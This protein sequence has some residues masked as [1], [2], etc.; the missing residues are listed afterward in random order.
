V[1][2]TLSRSS[3]FSIVSLFANA[4]SSFH[5]LTKLFHSVFSYKLFPFCTM[6]GSS[7]ESLLKQLQRADAEEASFQERCHMR[8]GIIEEIKRLQE[9]GKAIQ[10]MEAI[11]V[12]HSWV[13]ASLERLEFVI[14]QELKIPVSKEKIDKILSEIIQTLDALNSQ[15]QLLPFTEQVKDQTATVLGDD[16]IDTPNETPLE[17]TAP[18][19]H[20]M[21]YK[22]A[23]YTVRIQRLQSP[24]RG[25]QQQSTPTLP[26]QEGIKRPSEA[27]L[28][29]ELRRNNI[30]LFSSAD[31]RKVLESISTPGFVLSLAE[32][33]E[34]TSIYSYN[35]DGEIL[36]QSYSNLS[37]VEGFPT[38]IMKVPERIKMNGQEVELTS[39]YLMKLW[40]M[41]S[42]T[43]SGRLVAGNQL[44]GLQ[45]IPRKSRWLT[46]CS[47]S[48]PEWEACQKIAW[49]EWVTAFI[50][51]LI[52]LWS[53]GKDL[54]IPTIGLWLT[55][56]TGEPIVFG[57]SCWY[58]GA[59][60][61]LAKLR[62]E[63]AKFILIQD[64]VS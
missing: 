55:S 8:K 21:S 20:R 36:K 34:G 4:I 22:P 2:P 47:L 24:R 19:L 63:P 37:A 13:I 57:E 5:G 11:T 33:D 31:I 60:T 12:W 25:L 28:I 45:Q 32:E 43:V 1:R 53:K 46:V 3:L 17:K 49:D 27:E 40:S 42:N 15:I 7:I 61:Q 50:L 51:W 59:F 54:R 38:I 9:S 10:S 35:L 30:C 23:N 58:T 52:S 18:A 14:P 48:S 29:E 64:S 62:E 6:S 39:A 44:S 16:R 26:T 56:P 41:S